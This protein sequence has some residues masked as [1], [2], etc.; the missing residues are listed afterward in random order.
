MSDTGTETET[1]TVNGVDL[2]V[3]VAGDGPLVLLLHGFPEWSWSWR[4][5][6][7]ALAEAGY[8]VIAPDQRGYGHSDRPE[9]VEN[10]TIHHLVGD[11]AALVR[12]YTPGGSDP[13]AVVVGHDWGAMVAWSCALYR[14]DLFTAVMAMS[15]PF[16]PRMDM[17]LLDLIDATRGEDFHYIRYF[18]EPGVAEAELGADPTETIRWFAWMASGDRPEVPAPLGDG[19]QTRL[20]EAGSPPEG[21]PA[22]LSGGELSR[23]AEP[24]V[25][26]G[27]T[28]PLNWY[29]NLQRNWELTAAWNMTPIGV[30][31]G[32]VGGASDPVLSP[33]ADGT[34]N[35]GLMMMDQFVPDLR[36]RVLLD[37]VGHWNQQEDPGGTTAA[38]L[39][40]LSRVRG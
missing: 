38:L 28:A 17:S 39:D 3:T 20:F 7:P 13:E 1:V 22:F 5:Q 37:G 9:G 32:F 15:V 23:W 6:I 25:E 18:Q 2:A 29:R 35:M 24:F 26:G 12:H 34:P 19:S 21:T 14:P 10:Y 36:T 8:R 33:Q 16:V 4:H 30:P 27:F 31:A 40:F 11:A